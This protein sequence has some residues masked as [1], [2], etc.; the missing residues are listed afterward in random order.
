MY[1]VPPCPQYPLKHALTLS[2][3]CAANCW[4]NVTRPPARGLV[5]LLKGKPTAFVRL[6]DFGMFQ[7][8]RI[9]NGRFLRIRSAFEEEAVCARCL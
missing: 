1:E 4:Q 2:P 5:H 3:S 6:P 7:D 9:L 8:L